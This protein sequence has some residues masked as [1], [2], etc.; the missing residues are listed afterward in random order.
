MTHHID[1]P[2]RATM[3]CRRSD[4]R[5]LTTHDK[6]SASTYTCH[7]R[8]SS[9]NSAQI[10]LDNARRSTPLRTN[11]PHP[12]RE[13]RAPAPPRPPLIRRISARTKHIVDSRPLAEPS[14]TRVDGACSSLEIS[15]ARPRRASRPRDDE[16][17]D[18]LGRGLRRRMLRPSGGRGDAQRTTAKILTRGRAARDAAAPL[19]DGSPPEARRRGASACSPG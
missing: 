10:E 11:G 1:P 9:I 15:E 14:S 12:V 18:E 4:S 13:L 2:P 8:H 6:N 17:G 5:P 16:L 19:L 3:R 7:T